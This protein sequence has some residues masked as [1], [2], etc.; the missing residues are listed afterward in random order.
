MAKSK[1]PTKKELDKAKFLALQAPSTRALLT[2]DLNEAK[3]YFQGLSNNILVTQEDIASGK[4]AAPYDMY[5]KSSTGEYVYVTESD[6]DGNVWRYKKLKDVF[7][8]TAAARGA[9]GQLIEDIDSKSPGYVKAKTS[10]KSKAIKAFMD[11][12][13][14]VPPNFEGLFAKA[15]KKASMLFRIRRKSDTVKV[16]R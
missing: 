7:I 11:L 12:P 16:K 10:D 14:V 2:D 5:E 4:V 1:K 6:K 9:R 8:Q 3:E 15:A 13:G